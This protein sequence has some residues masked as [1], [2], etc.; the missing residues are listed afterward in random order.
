MVCGCLRDVAGCRDD[1]GCGEGDCG[2]FIA[3]VSLILNRLAIRYVSSEEVYI[4]ADGLHTFVKMDSEVRAWLA[5][6]F[7]VA[8]V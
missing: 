4:L 2:A 1:G 3:Q 7:S 8:H 5:L 6:F